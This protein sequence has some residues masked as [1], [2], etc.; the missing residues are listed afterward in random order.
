MY[1]ISAHVHVYVQRV[2]MSQYRGV[3][4]GAGRMVIFF[5]ALLSVLTDFNL[6][7]FAVMSILLGRICCRCTS[8]ICSACVCHGRGWVEMGEREWVG[9]LDRDELAA[10]ALI[11]SGMYTSIYNTSSW[12]CSITKRI[13]CVY[14]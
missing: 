13:L 6:K 10:V 2:R 9:V 12:M 7:I 4:V 8:L 1:I 11:L 14:N 5:K 3:N